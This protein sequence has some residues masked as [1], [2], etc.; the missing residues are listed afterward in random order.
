MEELSLDC[1][2]LSREVAIICQ[3]HIRFLNDRTTEWLIDTSHREALPASSYGR[4]DV[5]VIRPRRKA[6]TKG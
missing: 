4:I 6:H 2:Q 1:V 5:P 3:Q